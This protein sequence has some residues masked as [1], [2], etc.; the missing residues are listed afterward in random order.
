MLVLGR[1]VG[2]TIVVDGPCVITVAR[3]IRGSR[4]VRLGIEAAAGVRI[5]RGEVADLEEKDKRDACGVLRHA[6]RS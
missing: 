5:L 3:F 6:N 2:Q 4:K 1:E